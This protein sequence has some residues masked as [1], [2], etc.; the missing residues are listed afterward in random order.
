MP[1]DRW[2]FDHDAHNV[3]LSRGAIEEGQP[4]GSTK[5]NQ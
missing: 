2:A 5:E 3:K 1:T 4:A